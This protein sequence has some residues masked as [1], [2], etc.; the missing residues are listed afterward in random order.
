MMAKY[1]AEREKRAHNGGAKQYLHPEDLN[2]MAYE[3]DPYA[4][5]IIKREPIIASYD[6]VIIGAG[7]TS[8]QAAA[9]LISE[10][11]KNVCLIEKGSDVGGT[12]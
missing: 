2:P 9:R 8:L 11:F 12:W 7:Y 10:G 6:V 5:E 3:E 1:I 4:K